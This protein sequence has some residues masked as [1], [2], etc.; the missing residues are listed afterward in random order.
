MKEQ[1]KV[2]FHDPNDK[3]ETAYYL[4]NLLVDMLLDLAIENPHE[5]SDFVVSLLED[6]EIESGSIL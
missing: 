2:V 6:E 3:E 1:L 4:S 5:F